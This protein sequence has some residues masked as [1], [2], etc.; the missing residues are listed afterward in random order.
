MP[1]YDADLKEF[2]P[3]TYQDFAILLEKSKS[4][5]KYKNYYNIIK[6]QP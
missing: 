6:F 1:V 4:S 5:E 2:R 3:C